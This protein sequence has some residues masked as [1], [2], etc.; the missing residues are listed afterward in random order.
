MSP[1]THPGVF[2]RRDKNENCYYMQKEYISR[3]HTIF[4]NDLLNT[5]T[6]IKIIDSHSAYPYYEKS[7]NEIVFDTHFLDILRVVTA[8]MISEDENASI[9][10]LADA[11]SADYFLCKDEITD[12]CNRQREF[13]QCTE[14]LNT[15]L[16]CQRAEED[17]KQQKAV[18]LKDFRVAKLFSEISIV[19][20]ESKETIDEDILKSYFPKAYDINEEQIDKVSEAWSSKKAQQVY[21]GKFEMEFLRK[22]LESLIAENKAHTYFSE[23]YNCVHIN[24]GSNMLSSLSAYADTPIC[25]IAFLKAHKYSAS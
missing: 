19:K 2:V 25:L 15:W 18:V 24:P 13:H 5:N 16:C 11:C 22:I 23:V 1:Q 21:R 7:K 4:N 14:F 17:I 20:V 10:E 12:Y 3:L 8:I 6:T 9:D